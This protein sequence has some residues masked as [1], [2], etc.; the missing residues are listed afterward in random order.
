MTRP[1]FQKALSELP[2]CIVAMETCGSARHW[3][4]FA[5]AAGHEVGFIPA[6]YVKP[7][8]KL[9]KNDAIDVEAASRPSMRTEAVKDENQQA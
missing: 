3:A 7:F 1:K 9:H 2:P 6:L 5:Q 4:R 8:V